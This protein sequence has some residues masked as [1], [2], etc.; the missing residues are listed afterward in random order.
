MFALTRDR[1]EIPV[2]LSITAIEMQDG[3]CFSAFLHDISQRRHNEEQLRFL[4]QNDSL[5]GL[6]NCSLFYDRLD[7]PWC[8]V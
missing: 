2:E 7:G 4:A 6:P 1:G 3:W 8:A 5:T